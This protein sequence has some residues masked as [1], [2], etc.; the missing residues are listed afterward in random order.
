MA[1]AEYR[2]GNH[3]LLEMLRLVLPDVD[4]AS[5]RVVTDA[6]DGEEEIV[7]GCRFVATAGFSMPKDIHRPQSYQPVAP[8]EWDEDD[9]LATLTLDDEDD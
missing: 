3:D 5:V 7:T 4:W 1:S 6:E 2:F 9:A 8:H